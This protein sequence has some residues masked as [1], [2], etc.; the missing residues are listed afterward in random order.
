MMLLL[1]VGNTR[2]K[3]GLREA[4]R[5][6]AQGAFAHDEAW[7]FS[8][9]LPPPGQVA[10]VYGASVVSPELRARVAEAL[11]PWGH[12]PQW[13]V[14]AREACGVRNSYEVPTRLGADRWAALIGARAHGAAPCLVVTAG[15][16]TTI[17]VLD[18]DGV[19]RGGLIAPGVDLMRRALA[20]NTA[21]LP[22]VDGR[23][24]DL[25][26]CTADAIQMGC[27]HAQ[28]GAIER[29]YRQVADLPGA[30]CL[31]NGGAAA[32]IAP[33]LGIPWRQIDNLVLDGVA[34]AVGHGCFR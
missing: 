4:D 18:A 9:V 8:A 15:T 10:A 34:V 2:L 25:P 13:L 23:I 31:L 21:Q 32:Q 3:W 24:V 16:A 12:V 7:D 27:L 14:P 11:A 17:D 19:F 20:G 1:D 26:T 30:C 33:L 6:L 29:M 28:A 5:W 22:L